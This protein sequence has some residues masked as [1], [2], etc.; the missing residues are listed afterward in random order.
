M[1]FTFS[2]EIYTYI[3]VNRQTKKGAYIASK[4]AM[5]EMKANKN[6]TTTTKITEKRKKRERKWNFQE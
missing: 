5:C 2:K 1:K 6:N 4:V 3:N